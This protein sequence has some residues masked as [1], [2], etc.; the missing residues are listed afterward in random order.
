M[1]MKWLWEEWIE[2]NIIHTKVWMSNVSSLSGS[3]ICIFKDAWITNRNNSRNPG[4]N[5][6]TG[7]TLKMSICSPCSISSRVSDHLLMSPNSSLFSKL[8]LPGWTLSWLFFSFQLLSIAF[9]YLL[10]SIPVLLQHFKFCLII[11]VI[12]DIVLLF[13]QEWPVGL[14]INFNL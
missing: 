1:E 9:I 11:V 14:W 3:L 13:S 8:P 5:L 7:N 4:I 6:V 12:V 2:G 10:R